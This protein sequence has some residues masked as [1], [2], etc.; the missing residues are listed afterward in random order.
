MK[1]LLLTG[2][3]LALTLGA[4]ADTR[5]DEIARQ[6]FGLPK[7]KDTQASAV[8][9]IID[10]SGS[11]KLR[12]LEIYYRETAEGKDAFLSFSEPAD[13]AGTKFLTL[14]HRGG[15]SEQRLY[16][17]ALKKTRRISSDDQ[18]GAFVNSDFSFYDLEDRNFEDNTYT[19]LAENQSIADRAF[20][21]MKFYKIEMKPK[22]ASA[23]Y[24]RTI[25]YVNEDD[26]FVYRLDCFDRRGG[27]LLKT[28][29]FVKVENL[30]GYLIPT[31]TLV[32]NFKI[33]SKTLLAMSDLRVDIGLS[34]RIF[35][36]QNL[37]R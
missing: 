21:G 9:T 17:P 18:G 33:G 11:R 37:E 35:S 16:L 12:K 31:E 8:M 3:C 1:R 23:P 32:E 14:S 5:G 28:I 34:P 6:Y 20:E 30:K 36:V 25:A 29:L 7:A 22:D 13:I 27:A 4:F 15:S 24:S 2:L 19:F 26:H 10:R